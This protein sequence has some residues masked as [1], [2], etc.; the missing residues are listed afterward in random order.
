[1]RTLIM[2]LLQILFISLSFSMAMNISVQ[3]LTLGVEST[4]YAP[5]YYLNVE[6]KYQGAAR[7][8]FDL[9]SEVSDLKINYI[10]MPI[11]RLFNEFVKGNVGLKFPDNPLWSAS[12]HSTV[13]V[14]YSEPV[15][16]INE[17]L[18]VLKQ[19]EPEIDQKDMKSVGTI[20]GFSIPGIAKYVANN[21]FKTVKTREIE[22]LIHMLV[23]KRV[24]GVYFN[25]SVARNLAK[26]MYPNTSLVRHSKYPRFQYAYYISSI[27]HPKLIEAFNAFLISHAKQVDSIRNRY[28]LK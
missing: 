15:F 28:G 7:E 8:I 24:Q 23:S 22:Q 13:K 25:E 5:Y 16:N 4:N 19:D 21:E 20:L 2:R 11:P 14:H 26:K 18:L 1:M 3:A 17:S 12:L 10:P 27:K 6:K 9:F